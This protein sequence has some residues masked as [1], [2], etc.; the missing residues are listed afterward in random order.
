MS[1]AETLREIA[2]YNGCVGRH[3]WFSALWA[4]LREAVNIEA[5]RVLDVLRRMTD[6][7]RALT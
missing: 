1:W 4:V 6:A 7:R 2:V 5:L 3:C